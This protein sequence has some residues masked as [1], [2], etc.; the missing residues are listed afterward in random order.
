M[1]FFPELISDTVATAGPTTAS[2]T[3]LAIDLNLGPSSQS[4]LLVE[5]YTVIT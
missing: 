4:S 3:L 1:D 2:S 5:D